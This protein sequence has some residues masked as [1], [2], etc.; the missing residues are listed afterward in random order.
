LWLP[1]TLSYIN[2]AQPSFKPDLAEEQGQSFPV[3]HKLAFCHGYI[4]EVLDEYS[5]IG[6][7]TCDS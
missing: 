3:G 6:Y 1:K 2:L 7:S 5:K 4:V